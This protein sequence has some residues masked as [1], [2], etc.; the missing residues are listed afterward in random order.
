MKRSKWDQRIQRADELTSAHPFAAEAMR[1]YKGVATF[2]KELYAHVD[3][4]RGNGSGKKAA[5][6]FNEDLNLPLLLPKFPEFL[7]RVSAFS[8]R[9]VAESA[10]RLRTQPAATVEEM[11]AFHWRKASNSQP[12]PSETETLLAWIFLQPYAECLADRSEH[13]PGNDSLALCPFCGG[14]PLVGVL[15][16]EGDGAKR[17]LICALCSTEWAFRRILCPAC[18]EESVEKLAV[19][20]AAEFNHVRVEG[21]DTCQHYIKTVDLT[22]NGLAVPVVDELATIPLNLWAQEHGYVKLRTNLLGI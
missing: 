2:Q 8:P 10:A 13:E 17:F 18:G 7:S 6:L 14:K 15:R 16:P 21:C 11:L 3:A 12:A 4:A 19:Y 20:T 22:K 5:G 9:P 1:F